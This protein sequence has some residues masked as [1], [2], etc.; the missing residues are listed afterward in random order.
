[1]HS[2]AAGPEFDDSAAAR[3]TATSVRGNTTG[4]K[5][6]ISIPDEV[7]AETEHLAK[8]LG[9]SRSQIYSRALREFLARHSPDRVTELMNQ[10]IAAVGEKNDPFVERAARHALRRVEW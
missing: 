4:M 5:V 1:M 2:R 6:A 9:T 8:R 10:A 7:F 3:L